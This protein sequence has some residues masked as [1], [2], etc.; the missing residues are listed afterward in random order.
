MDND[1]NQWQLLIFKQLQPL[2]IGMGPYGVMNETRIFIPGWTMWGALTKA[3]NV[4]SGENLSENQDLFEYISCFWPA[5]DPSDKNILFPEFRNGK[6]Q[7]GDYSEDKFRL[8][9]VETMVSTAI[10]P[11]SRMATDESLHEIDVLLPAAKK[12]LAGNTELKEL[13]WVGVFKINDEKGEKKVEEFLGRAQSLGNAL[14]IVVGGESRYGLG[15]LA[16]V[17]KKPLTNNE[18]LEQFKAANYLSVEIAKN[19]QAP[20]EAIALI[21][22]SQKSELK[23]KDLTYCFAP[24]I[25]VK[26]KIDLEKLSLKKGI[27]QKHAN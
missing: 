13:F 10:T 1:S 5:F 23:I 2:H 18:M 12:A 17:E 7:L 15:R 25:Q 27:L 14:Q 3:Y 11:V 20:I 16:L 6:F 22:S 19:V 4:Y 8:Q 9:F 21:D 26:G 24:D